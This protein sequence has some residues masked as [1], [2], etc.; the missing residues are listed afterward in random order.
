MFS[1]HRDFFSLAAIQPC[2]YRLQVPYQDAVLAEKQA[3]AE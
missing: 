1:L 2:E 3:L